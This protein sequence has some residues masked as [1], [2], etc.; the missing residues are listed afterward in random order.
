MKHTST[1]SSLVSTI[2]I[3][4]GL[5]LLTNLL[6]LVR[7]VLF[8]RAFG[9]TATADCYVTAATIVATCFLIFAA[10]SLQGAFMPRYQRALVDGECGRAVGLWRST[11]WSLILVL[12]LITAGLMLWPGL[13][14][15]WVVPGFAAEQQAQ[16]ANLLVW[17][18]PMAVLVGLGSLLQSVAHA[19][20]RFLLPA[21]V[22]ALNNLLLIAA[23]VLVVPAA[24][25]TGFAQSTLIGTC[26]WLVLWPLAQRLLPSVP[27]APRAGDLGELASAMLPLVLLLVADQVGALVQKALVSDLEAGSIAVLNYAARLEG[28]PV[29]I[30]AAAISAVFFPA[31]VEALSRGDGVHIGQR[32]RTGIAAVLFFSVPAAVFLTLEAPLTV[33]VLLERGA[34]DPAASA[35]AAEALT[36]YAVGLV[37][38][39]LIVYLHRAFYATGDT[40][41]PM[42]VGIFSAVLHVLLCWQLVGPFGYL[43]I[44][45][46][47]TAY[48]IL[49]VALLA[50]YLPHPM[51]PHLPRCWGDLWRTATAGA[52][53]A[54]LYLFWPFP[55]TVL[56]L[57]LALAGGGMV[58]VTVMWMIGDR[59]LW[60]GLHRGAES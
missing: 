41:T 21:M 22:P 46:G 57:T 56:G 30:F 13:W 18:A 6:A 27:P 8:A 40:R 55:A 47:T 38:Q 16:T 49:Y 3:V 29:G 60:L 32:F 1:A 34:F 36:W 44:A 9:A 48:A 51:A 11:L 7:E 33:R 28:L 50:L 19:H 42:V 2:G 52:A 10:G 12:G 25:V 59:N 23:L 54:A 58:Y 17:M 15:G 20:R 45:M 14:V 26:A 53:M 39:S 4:S 35:R 24:G 43:G 37:P 31:L 5:T